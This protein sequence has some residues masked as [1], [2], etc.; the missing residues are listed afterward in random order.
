MP[1]EPS[2]SDQQYAQQGEE[3]QSGIPTDVIDV[4]LLVVCGVAS[5]RVERYPSPIE[6]SESKRW[7]G[8]ESVLHCLPDAAAAAES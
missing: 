1:G 7:V 3:N 5:A 6:G 2:G 4:E 8:F